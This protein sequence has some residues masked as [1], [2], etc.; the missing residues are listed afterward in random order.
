MT[1]Q[2]NF[3]TVVGNQNTFL[4]NTGVINSI[5][6][7]NLNVKQFYTLTESRG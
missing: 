1:Y 4:Y 2:F 6:S 5:N 7:A 3:H